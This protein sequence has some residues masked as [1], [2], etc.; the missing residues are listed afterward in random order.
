VNDPRRRRIPFDHLLQ[1]FRP[2]V[3]VTTRDL[4]ASIGKYTSEILVALP[5]RQTHF[6]GSVSLKLENFQAFA[7]S[8][9]PS[10]YKASKPSVGVPLNELTL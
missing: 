5:S 3:N 1:S 9:S 7:W 8:R 2:W 4:A 6:G 10:A